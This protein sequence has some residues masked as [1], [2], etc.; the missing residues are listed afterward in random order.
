MLSDKTKL[1]KTL[2]LDIIDKDADRRMAE[3]NLTELQALID[4]VGGI[5][6]E[7]I[8]QKRGRPS[9]KTFLGSGK[10]REAANFAKE[11]N[12]ELIILNGML[13]P[14]QYLHLQKVFPKMKLW[15]RVDLIL[16]IFDKHAT[17][18]LAQTQIKLARMK[19][20]IPKIYARQATTLFE[21]AGAGIGTRGAGERGI[22]E[23]KRHIRRQIKQLE[24]QLSLA[25]T[26]QGQQRK[27]RKRTG[28]ITA[29]LVGYTNVGKSSLMR[30][31]TK[32]KGIISNNAL[33]TTLET[34]LG[35]CWNSVLQ[36]EILIADTI[37]FIRDLPP[38]LISSFLA[39]LEEAKKSDI[40]VH[41]ID[42]SDPKF[43]EKIKVVEEIL[44]Q[45][46]CENIP[47]IYVFNKI[48]QKKRVPIK[49]INRRFKKFFPVFISCVKK[50]GIEDL[51]TQIGSL[52]NF[53]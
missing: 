22:E 30:H 19:H 46:G 25:Q 47:R 16:N 20:E 35:R 14:N 17:S 2:I 40:L 50:E 38:S 23:E 37:G 6:V 33:F 21:R 36:Q 11:E 26:K 51:K 1:L 44:K 8:I 10:I 39:T 24:D 32:K 34:K 28:M 3:E 12:I 31:L 43:Y 15:D 27:R 5:V 42:V 41:V 45:I 48:D 18:S 7:K 9:A 13:K 4:A 49:T 29:T 53:L 52:I